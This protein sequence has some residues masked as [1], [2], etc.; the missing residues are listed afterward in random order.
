[1]AASRAAHSLR[2]PGS[3]SAA[4]TAAGS[5][6]IPSDRASSDEE[7]ASRMEGNILGDTKKLA[8]YNAIRLPG[9]CSVNDVA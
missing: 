8:N 9:K 4:W 6:A 2:L 1:M 7:A 3:G 5:K